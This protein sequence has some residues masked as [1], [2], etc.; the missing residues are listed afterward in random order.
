MQAKSN[1]DYII[2]RAFIHVFNSIFLDLLRFLIGYYPSFTG[3][4]FA[5]IYRR[6]QMKIAM[7]EYCHD[8]QGKNV[9]N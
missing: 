5:E 1:N 9:A 7:K 3:A 6:G 4:I 8:K 2:N